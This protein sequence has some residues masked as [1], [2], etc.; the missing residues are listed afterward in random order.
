MVHGLTTAG[1][2]RL[3]RAVTELDARTL[4]ALAHPVRLR[5]VAAIGPGG[6]TGDRLA[7][8]LDDVSADMCWHHTAIL[9][10]AG[11][12]ARQRVT[13]GDRR[14]YVYRLDPDVFVGVA[15]R[16]I[17]IDNYHP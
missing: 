15:D 10:R 4:A 17:D 11:L 3:R 6:T 2:T 5:I 7:S 9:R 8:T 12:V 14:S 13:S 1:V 16:L